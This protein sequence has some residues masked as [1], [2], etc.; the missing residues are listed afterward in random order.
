MPQPFRFAR[1][2][3]R[4]LA[5][6]A[7]PDPGWAFCTVCGPA[8]D[9]KAFP[10][11]VPA[12]TSPCALPGGEGPLPADSR[13]KSHAGSMRAR[14]GLAARA[15]RGA[16]MAQL[17]EIIGRVRGRAGGT[18]GSTGSQIT[19]TRTATLKTRPPQ[20]RRPQGWL[21]R[22]P[23]AASCPARCIR[24]GSNRTF[25]AQK[26]SRI[27]IRPVPSTSATSNR[28]SVRLPSGWVAANSSA[29]A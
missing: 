6:R 1:C 12:V 29:V 14:L 20:A 11:R 7:T 27:S 9:Q 23:Q 21:P 3:P 19:G 26:F 25:Q 28:I 18:T 13:W 2:I 15:K 17:D 16:E 5:M 10:P 4:T 8:I 24:P 22:P